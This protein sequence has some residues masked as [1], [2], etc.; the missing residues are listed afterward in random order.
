MILEWEFAARLLA[1]VHSASLLR[2]PDREARHAAQEGFVVD[3]R[4]VAKKL[5]KRR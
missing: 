3:F 1:T 2:I 4:V 5:K